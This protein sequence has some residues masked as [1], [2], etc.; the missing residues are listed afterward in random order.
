MNH[1]NERKNKMS[2]MKAFVPSE[3]VQPEPKPRPQY[4]RRDIVLISLGCLAMAGALRLLFEVW[5]YWHPFHP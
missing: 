5:Q 1:E 2:K 3:P 4:T